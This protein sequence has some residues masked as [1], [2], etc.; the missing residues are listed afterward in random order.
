MFSNEQLFEFV[1]KLHLRCE[2]AL[3]LKGSVS[4]NVR[5]AENNAIE[6]CR[7][8]ED[9][10]FYLRDS[11]SFH[12]FKKIV[13][14]VMVELSD[15]AL[16]LKQVRTPSKRSS[17]SIEILSNDFPIFAIDV[18]L[19]VPQVTV[20]SNNELFSGELTE[21][22]ALVADKIDALSTERVL[23]RVKDIYDLYLVSK[24]FQIEYDKIKTYF[25]TIPKSGKKQ[26]MQQNRTLFSDFK[27][28]YE[29]LHEAYLERNDII[30]K[31]D[32][33][34]VYLGARAMVKPF[35]AN[36]E[37][38]KDP[39]AIWSPKDQTWR[40][41]FGFGNPLKHQTEKMNKF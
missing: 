6:E 31:P 20:R 11:M 30:I 34:Q 4:L 22:E 17:G 23:G 29:A 24:Y 9:V 27:E 5:V 37:E 15:N 39:K 40:V 7:L 12:T 16:T 25:D 21:L 19:Y 41:D 3:V 13:Q 14:E 28:N 36:E 8:T 38:I 26:E 33:E 18:D 32:F 1:E 35:L 10:D 2:N